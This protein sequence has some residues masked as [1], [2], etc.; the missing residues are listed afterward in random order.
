MF[1]IVVFSH[2]D[3]CNSSMAADRINQ[4]SIQSL[5][6]ENSFFYFEREREADKVELSM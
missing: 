3:I 2:E 6:T 1:L 4:R 5:F